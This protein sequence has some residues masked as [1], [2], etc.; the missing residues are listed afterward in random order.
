VGVTL[1]L[2]EN[3]MDEFYIL[4]IFL[5][6][7]TAAIIFYLFPWLDRRAKRQRYLK[8]QQA[9]EDAIL[10][11]PAHHEGWGLVTLHERRVER[12]REE[13]SA[14]GADPF[15]SFKPF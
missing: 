5:I 3:V 9:L 8:A 2:K 13:M 11:A 14:M 6:G 4:N 1:N 12:L 7:S 10:S 15:D